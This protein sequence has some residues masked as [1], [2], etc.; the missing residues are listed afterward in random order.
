MNKLYRNVKMTNSCTILAG[1]TFIC[2]THTMNKKL[3]LLAALGLTF[4]SCKKDWTCTCTYREPGATADSAQAYPIPDATRGTAHDACDKSE[5]GARIVF[6][7]DAE[8]ELG[9]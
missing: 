2:N 1:Q 5:E 3:L 9:D 8:C 4:A 6:S 7:P